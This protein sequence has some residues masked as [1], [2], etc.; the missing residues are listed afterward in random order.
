MILTRDVEYLIRLLDQT[1]KPNSPALASR[2][3]RITGHEFGEDAASWQ[4]W[5]NQK[6]QL[7]QFQ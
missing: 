1:K 2:L 6:E 4:R 3:K 7:K 5:W